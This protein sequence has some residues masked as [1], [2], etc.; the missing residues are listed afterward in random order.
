MIEPGRAAVIGA[1]FNAAGSDVVTSSDDGSARVW[2]A[3]TGRQLEVLSEPGGASIYSAAFNANGAEVVTSSADGSAR[4]WNAATGQLLTA[5]STGF[6]VRDSVF[7]PNGSEVLSS[8]FGGTT[9]AWSTE[10]AGSLDTLE[11]IAQHRV[12]RQLTAAE[13]RAYL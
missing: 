1:A 7:T 6:E 11:R 10:L 2:D 13:R 9:I 4:I 5:F 3:D 8:T 12:T